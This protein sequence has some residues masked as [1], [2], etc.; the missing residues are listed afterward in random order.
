L[1]TFSV[2]G[3]ELLTKSIHEKHIYYKYIIHGF[4][5]EKNW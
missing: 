2:P 1:E 3:W 5:I 4:V